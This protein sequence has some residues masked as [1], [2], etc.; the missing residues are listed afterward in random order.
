MVITEFPFIFT[1]TLMQARIECYQ[2]VH[3]E[4]FGSRWRLRGILQ[5]REPDARCAVH[6]QHGRQHFDNVLSVWRVQVVPEAVFVRGECGAL[7]EVTSTNGG[8]SSVL[9]FTADGSNDYYIVAEPH[10]NGPGG[11]FVLNVNAVISSIVATP[12]SLGV[13]Q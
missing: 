4:S 8:I 11:H 1:N 9:T 12:S 5:A 10:N 6:D 13:S 7:I 2:R 3:P